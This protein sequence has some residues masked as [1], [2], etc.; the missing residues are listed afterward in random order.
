MK[1]KKK[2]ESKK[3]KIENCFACYCGNSYRSCCFYKF[4]YFAEI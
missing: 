3:E 1:T 4:K 2:V